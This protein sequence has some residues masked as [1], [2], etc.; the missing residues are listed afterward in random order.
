MRP[1]QRAKWYRFKDRLERHDR[2]N[3]DRV[4]TSV[5]GTVVFLAIVL[6]FGFLLTVRDVTP[7]VVA[8]F[9]GYPL[10]VLFTTWLVARKKSRKRAARATRRTEQ[11][12]DL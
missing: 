1:S 8:F 2:R 6:P 10:V 5:W 7:T 9:V 4:G 3:A 12:Q 11:R